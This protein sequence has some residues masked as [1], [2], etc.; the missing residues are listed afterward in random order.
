VSTAPNNVPPVDP[1]VLDT[2]ANGLELLDRA[3]RLAR[4]LFVDNESILTQPGRLQVLG[5]HISENDALREA[6]ETGASA[7]E[8]AVAWRASLSVPNLDLKIAHAL[9]VLYRESAQIPGLDFRTVERFWKLSTSLWLLL[10]A[11]PAFLEEFSKKRFGEERQDLTP[12]QSDALVDRALRRIL[13]I[14]ADRGAGAWSAGRQDEARLHIY[15]LNLPCRGVGALKAAVNDY[16][17]DIDVDDG[18]LSRAADMAR[19]HLDAWAD[20]VV[21]ECKAEIE[22]VSSRPE[23]ADRIYAG[24]ISRLERFINLQVP[25]E[26]A[27]RAGLEWY[28]FWANSLANR[29]AF[30]RLPQWDE[31]ASRI[32]KELAVLAEKGRAENPSSQAVSEYFVYHGCVCLNQ[33][34]RRGAREAFLESLEW[35]P[36]NASA[37]ELLEK[38]ES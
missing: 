9:A 20:S 31:G 16:G 13:G 1:E 34:D 4:V 37:Q 5:K 24:A 35:N 28:F 10:L 17:I 26:R 36:E 6:I 18:R 33:R 27:L 2:Y 22:E 29:K 14:H 3:T 19:H 25:V 12:E 7:K 30:D 11:C 38:C 21:S 23:D 8:I 15:C 32:A